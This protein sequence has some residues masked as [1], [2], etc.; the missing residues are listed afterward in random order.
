L[1]VGE[2]PCDS[3]AEGPRGAGE[4]VEYAHYRTA[5][6]AAAT[7]G[8]LARAEELLAVALDIALGS[9]DSRLAD[10]AYCN[11]AAV[12]IELAPRDEVLPRLRQILV[13]HSDP[14]SYR[15]AAYHLARAYEQRKDY[16][17]G[18]FYARIAIEQT[19]NL[20][21]AEP[22][23]LSTSHHQIGNLLVGS[24]FFRGAIESYE[25]ALAA[26][27]AGGPESRAAV[28]WMNVGY[29]RVML[30]EVRSGVAQLIQSLRVLR[31]HRHLE[32]ERMQNHLDLALGYLELGRP[33]R[34]LRHAA[35]GLALAERHGAADALKNAL[36]LLG[37]GAN[38]SGDEDG[39]RGYY[40]QLQR[41][42]PATPFLP[43]L[44]LAI[45]VRKLINLRA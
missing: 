34:V 23:W 19:K 36:F 20:P 5:G 41:Y 10:R 45:D 28:I 37:E 30:G 27:P 4:T 26:Y 39:A 44:L 22:E 9:G 8:D 14:E 35:T 18:L 40:E 15:L 3:R 25:A 6:V 2:M 29:C 11:L 17:K 1:S 32:R 24:S 7:R 38:L 12:Q 42:F 21:S 33:R 13:R 16:K 31:R 43:D